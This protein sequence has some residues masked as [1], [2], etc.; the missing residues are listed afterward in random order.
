[1]IKYIIFDFD[2]TLVDSGNAFLNIFLELAE[3]YGLR[4]IEHE[5][6]ASLRKMTVLEKCKTL[7][8]PLY[9][10]PSLASEFYRSYKLVIR[11]LI[12]FDG[13]Q[14]LLGE[15][16]NSGYEIAIVSSNSKENIKSFLLNSG[17]IDHYQVL[18]SN[19][20]LGKDIM[21]K[22]F[23]KSN[24]LKAEEVIYI[25]DEH[26][27][28]VACKKCKINIIWVGWGF[29]CLEAVQND[30]PDYVVNAPGEIINI[31]EDLQRKKSLNL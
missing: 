28:I 21:L 16:K 12:L 9:K 23:L 1:M 29:D 13:I 27:D 7:K 20:I 15:L 25:G 10:L 5:E 6:I 11:D 2:G 8:I 26:R 24:N 19:N 18:S 30:K 31:L 3:K 17:L 22:K 14:E 4:K